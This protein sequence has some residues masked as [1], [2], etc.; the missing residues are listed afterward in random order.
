MATGLHSSS[1]PAVGISTLA[2]TR[3]VEYRAFQEVVFSAKQKK[4]REGAVTL[5]LLEA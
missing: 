3:I 1:G 4:E 2:R 5:S